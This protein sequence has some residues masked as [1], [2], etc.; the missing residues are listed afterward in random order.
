MDYF[1]EAA[2]PSLD[3][4]DLV[5]RAGGRTMVEGW[6][7]DRPETL[8]LGSFR[9]TGRGPVDLVMRELDMP[10]A[11]GP[12]RGLA[13]RPVSDA[14]GERLVLGYLH[15]LEAGRAAAASDRFAANAVY[16]I[17]DAGGPPGAQRIVLGRQA[18]HD[19]FVARGTNDAR[20]HVQRVAGDGHG[21]FLV[22]G[23]VSGLSDG[24]EA[25]FVSSLW[26]DSHALIVR[27]VTA[28]V[29]PRVRETRTGVA[30]GAD[31]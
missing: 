21:R 20:H 6:H 1:D 17:P 7:P 11:L 9:E 24:G 15:D 18:I 30:G 27:Y 2:P 10:P 23:W 4:F 29:V 25:S 16:C 26:V 13:R 3:E 8:L 5:L 19:A 31:A 22:D 14:D 28:L 12:G